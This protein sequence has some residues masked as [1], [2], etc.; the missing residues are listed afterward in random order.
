MCQTPAKTLLA[1]VPFLLIRLMLLSVLHKKQFSSLAGS[2]ICSTPLKMKMDCGT[3]IHNAYNIQRVPY[4]KI[5]PLVALD[6]M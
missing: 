1:F 3:F 6:V 4:Q 5:V 2:S